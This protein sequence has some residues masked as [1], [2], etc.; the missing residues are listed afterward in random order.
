MRLNLFEMLAVMAFATPA[1]AQ[2]PDGASVARTTSVRATVE[3]VDQRTRQIV[4]SDAEGGIETVVAHPSIRRLAEI[5]PGDAVVVEYGEA[6]AVSL[7]NPADG[8]P[9]MG[10]G[11]AA[12]RAQPRLPPGGAVAGGIRARVVIGAVDARTGTVTFTGPKGVQRRVRPQR[13]EMVDFAR[14]LRPGQQ[15]DIVYGEAIAMRVEPMRR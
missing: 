3:S 2:V 7:A 6:L 12:A 4:L 1:L 11:V 13:P 5:R 9:A 15:V 8:A 14:G 10:E